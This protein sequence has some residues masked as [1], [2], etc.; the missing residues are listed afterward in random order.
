MNACT[1][2]HTLLFI[3]FQESMH[4]PD[5]V[6]SLSIQPESSV[7]HMEFTCIMFYM[8]MCIT[9]CLQN[10]L[11]KFSKGI[12]RFQKEDPT[13]K[14]RYDEESKE[15][16]WMSSISWTSYIYIFYLSIIMQT[17][18]SGMGELHLEIYAEVPITTSIFS[19]ACIY[20]RNVEDAY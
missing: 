4:V 13:F 18:I 5:P 1:C 16:E 3:I 12:N 19:S 14:V 9:D 20:V 15:V 8:T 6:I 11:E 10:D 7:M 2:A 17:I